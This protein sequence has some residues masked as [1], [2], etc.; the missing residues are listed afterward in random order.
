MEDFVSALWAAA[1]LIVSAGSVALATFVRAWVNARVAE[2]EDGRV[3]ARLQDGV[4]AIEAAIIATAGPVQERLRAAG[5]D[6]RVTAEERRGIMEL[7]V[8]QAQEARSKEFWE[9][10]AKDHEI[11]EVGVWIA[12]QAEALI[13]R[14]DSPALMPPLREDPEP[15]E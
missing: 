4:A 9:K 14:E 12:D 1:A 13:F 6:G 5:K 15:G 10:L 11:A 8:K 2:I 3:R 7:V